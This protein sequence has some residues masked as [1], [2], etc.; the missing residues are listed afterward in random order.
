VSEWLD[1]VRSTIDSAASGQKIVGSQ[2][3]NKQRIL[4]MNRIMQ[5]QG[6]HN[7]YN[8]LSI[9]VPICPW[10]EIFDEK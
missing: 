8:V 9:C 1:S 7:V 6:R 4:E 2:R 3:V 10:R 5:H